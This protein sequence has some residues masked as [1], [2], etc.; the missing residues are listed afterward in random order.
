MT[1]MKAKVDINLTSKIA[2]KAGSIITVTDATVLGLRLAIENPI[3]RDTDLPFV[4]RDNLYIVE[5]SEMANIIG[6]LEDVNIDL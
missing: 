4:H 3:N 1:L 5:Y 2:I 6:D